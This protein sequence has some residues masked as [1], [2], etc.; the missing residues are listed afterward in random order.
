MT[1]Y[2]RAES[3]ALL[4]EALHASC[5]AEWDI[6]A[7]RGVT[8][9]TLHFPDAHRD[10][11]ADILAA[12]PTLARR[13]DLGTAWDEAVAALPEW[14]GGPVLCPD[15]FDSVWHASALDRRIASS[16]AV[17]VTANGPTPTEAL[18]ALAEAL[19]ED[20]R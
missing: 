18:V 16:Q 14:A 5:E 3:V 20:Q 9:M 1:T 4:A 2:I 19:R 11:A 10:R 13:L 12:S 15:M 17:D 6:K 7:A 8:E